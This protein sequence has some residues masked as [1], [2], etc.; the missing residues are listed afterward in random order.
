MTTLTMP[1]PNTGPESG[2]LQVT[3]STE[4]AT[5]CEGL[6]A[7]YDV[8]VESA[9]TTLDRLATAT[10]DEL[11]DA[12]LTLDPFPGMLDEIRV[13]ANSLP[14]SVSANTAVAVTDPVL[15]LPADRQPVFSVACGANPPGRCVGDFAGSP[16]ADLAG[17]GGPT[18]PGRVKPAISDPA[19]EAIGLVSL[20]NLVAGYFESTTFDANS[21]SDDLSFSGWLRNI[22]NNVVVIDDSSTPLA[23]MLVRVSSADI[24]STTTAEIATTPRATATDFPTVALS[25]AFPVTAV[26]A[27]MGDESAALTSS[28]GD[29]LIAA[30][31]TA[32][33][34]DA[35]PLPAS[36]FNALR[37]VWK[38]NNT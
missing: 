2:T 3:C 5:I 33:A 30:G 1:S 6:G 20:A 8:T 36:T 27:T 38:D 25:P 31:W 7:D 15:S 19:V 13:R 18:I 24:A 35:E 16:W 14:A 4:F 34:A 32:P 22:T 28:L 23:T 26:L 11:P 9:G 21:S 29:A 17:A 10:D 12:W 37:K